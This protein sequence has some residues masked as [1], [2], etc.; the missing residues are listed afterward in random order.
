MRKLALASMAALGVAISLPA[1]AGSLYVFGD[2]LSDDGNLF[3]LIGLPPAPYYQGRFSNGPVWVEY[4]PS[5][6]DLSGSSA[7]NYAYGGAFTGN[8]TI[9]GVDHG[10]NVEGANL[11]GITTEIAGFAAAGGH[12]GAGDVVTLWGGANNFFPITT[13]IEANPSQAVSLVTSGVSTAITQLTA[14]AT[15]LAQL[16]ARTLIVPNLPDLGKT[17]D[18]NTSALGTALGNAFASL[19]DAALPAAM[20]SVH[21]ATGANIIVLNTETLLNNVIANPSV[22]GFTNVTQACINVAAC[23]NGDAAT[24]SQYVFWDGVHPTTHAQYYIARYAAASL[25]QFESLSIPGQLGTQGALDFNGLLDDRLDALRAGATGLSYNLDGASG[26]HATPDQ[27]FAMFITAGGGFGNRDNSDESLGYGY[28]DAVTAIGADYRFTDNVM[29]GLALGYGDN[30]ADVNESAGTVH[31]SALQVG[32]YALGQ[33]NNAYVQLAGSYGHGWYNTQAPGVIGNGPVGKPN[34]DAYALDITGGYLFPVLP[35]VHLGPEAALTY[36]NNSLGAYTQTGDALLTQTVDDQG[37]EQLIATTSAVATAQ[38]QYRDVAISPY[39]K[40]GAQILLSGRNSTFTSAFTDE[41]VVTLT[42]TYP[43][44]PPAWAVFTVGANAAI[45]N[46]LAASA[47][48]ETTGF[49]S[50]GNNILLSA[51]LRYSF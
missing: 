11:P 38:L 8:L 2:S 3:K 26:T 48:L 1:R 14:D 50:D 46:Q 18:Y 13:L 33:W 37:Y 10:T 51:G 49:K 15:S 34:G 41:P 40:I 31:E 30:H 29:A 22:F 42:S 25:N 20:E 43:K 44:Q 32:M 28:R 21:N 23:V 4:L 9:D 47:S 27:K 39:A 6:T 7:N 16:G 36:T 35:N 24:Q 12:F 45:T 5:L 17:P 19:H